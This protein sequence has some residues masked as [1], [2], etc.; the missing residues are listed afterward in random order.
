MNMSKENTE[1]LFIVND[2]G[3]VLQEIGTDYQKTI[4]NTI[5]IKP[6]VPQKELVKIEYPYVKLNT[7]LPK[8]FYKEYPQVLLF[9]K[10]IEYNTNLLVFPNGK[11]VNQTNMA[12][13]LGYSRVYI[14]RLFNK[15]KKE[16]IIAPIKLD[17]RIVYIFNPYIAMMGCYVYKEHMAAFENNKWEELSDTKKRRKK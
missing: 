7:S 13:D 12:K 8:G 15:F 11:Y 10:Y 16:Q 3:E 2:K 17:R 1:L 5:I 9:L 4:N 14:S 6:R